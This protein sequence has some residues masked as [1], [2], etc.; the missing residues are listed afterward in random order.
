VF[1][2]V[3][4]VNYDHNCTRRTGFMM[5]DFST[6]KLECHWCAVGICQQRTGYTIIYCEWCHHDL[7]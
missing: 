7:N 2:S 4:E 6:L 3:A 1:I 5:S